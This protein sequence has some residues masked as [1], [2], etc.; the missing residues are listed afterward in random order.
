MKIIYQ[1]A[2]DAISVL[3]DIMVH[4]GKHVIN[5]RSIEKYYEKQMS[6]HGFK[7]DCITDLLLI[8]RSQ[9][10]ETRLNERGYKSAGNGYFV[11]IEK[12]ADADYLAM[13]YMNNESSV[14]DR[15]NASMLAMELW[16]RLAKMGKPISD[17]YLEFKENEID[18]KEM[19]KVLP[20]SDIASLTNR[21]Q[22]W[23]TQLKIF[24]EEIA[25]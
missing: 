24:M 1:I 18:I 12:C 4:S 7:N 17:M 16:S 19:V 15:E 3:E 6:I 25:N 14:S 22:M 11:N 9:V 2:D 10:I 8:G 5:R 23:Q 21:I 20:R 13:V